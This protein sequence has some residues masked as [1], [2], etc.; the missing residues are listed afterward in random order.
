[1]YVFGAIGGVNQQDVGQIQHVT[2]RTNCHRQHDYPVDSVKIVD[3]IAN[4]VVVPSDLLQVGAAVVR[5][6]PQLRD[7]LADAHIFQSDFEQ[8]VE[9]G[10]E[11]LDQQSRLNHPE[12]GGVTNVKHDAP[13]DV[14]LENIQSERCDPDVRVKNQNGCHVQV[15]NDEVGVEACPR[16][17]VK[18]SFSGDV[19]G[20][21]EESLEGVAAAESKE[22]SQK[23]VEECERQVGQ[24]VG[25]DHSDVERSVHIFFSAV[26]RV[27]VDGEDDEDVDTSVEFEG[28]G[29]GSWT[30]SELVG[31]QNG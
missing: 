26:R 29:D 4:V 11:M 8:A 20:T 1:L 10:E 13:P 23:D 24:L 25:Y 22:D 31:R 21:V 15:E 14:K 19:V 16:Q 7:V 28:E 6:V 3:K 9:R 12:H 27:G 2:D 30:I 5:S 18:F 17:T